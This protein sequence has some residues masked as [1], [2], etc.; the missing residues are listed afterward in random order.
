MSLLLS[1]CLTLETTGSAL[2]AELLGSSW[3]PYLLV[4]PA[5]ILLSGQPSIFPTAI[6]KRK[7]PNKTSEFRATE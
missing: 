5:I 1:L 6:P 4:L 2:V 7:D 3:S